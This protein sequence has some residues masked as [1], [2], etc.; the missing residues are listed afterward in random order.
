MGVMRFEFHPPDL[1]EGW[2]EIHR[3]FLRGF[4]GRV[5]STRIEI[6]G[7]VMICRRQECESSKLSVPWPVDGFGRPIV[8]TCSMIEREEP[9]LLHLELARGKISQI[10]DQA[11]AWE[12]AGLRISDE[13][14]NLST[15]A[16]RLF[17]K[18][19]TSQNRPEE[20]SELACAALQKSFEASQHLVQTCTEQRLI[21]RRLRS[22]RLP[23]S[24]GCFLGYSALDEAHW[25]EHF[26]EAF[27][28]AAIPVEWRHI[29]PTEGES[30]WD[31][32]DAQIEWCQNQRLMMYGGPLL[33]FSTEGLPGWLSQWQ[34]DFLNLKSF[35]SNFVET[36]VSRYFGKIR[37]WEISAR[38]N[39]GGA[40]ALNE[41]NRLALVAHTLDVARQVDEEIQLM[42]RVDQPWG[43]YLAR[44]QHRLSP[45]Q[46]V[47]ALMRSGIGLSGVNLEISVGY[48]PRGCGSRDL[49]EFSRL[50]D[51]W[52]QLG[53]PL[54]VTLAFP[55][56]EGADRNSLTD[57][58]VDSPCWKQPWSE[59]SQLKWV[60]EFFPLLLAKESVVGIYW[61]HFAD[62]TA[63]DFP[64][65]GLIRA[66]GTPK[67]ALS[68]FVQ[69]RRKFWEMPLDQ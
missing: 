63:H 36:A 22:P 64:H 68:Q 11:G 12:I 6:D 61:T 54:Y 41:E 69:Y 57:L 2:P 39:T 46:F 9:Y 47:D 21:I 31:I 10:R 28:A 60:H 18:A 66:N 17:T 48:R 38:A 32:S 25:D 44:G 33:D 20:S 51:L 5:F 42:I 26:C 16:H 30:L 50:I 40:L 67:P 49:L 7:N 55:S 52:S 43:D 65:A 35:F 15:E 56:A 4:D 23:A 8:S 27:N 58:E 29:E 19:V 13:F 53:I 37:I 14:Q 24:L 34:N 62:S 45:L 3:A 59:A 1:L